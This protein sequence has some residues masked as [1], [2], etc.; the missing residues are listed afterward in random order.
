MKKYLKLALFIA[1]IAA[2]LTVCA[3]AEDGVNEADKT[4]HTYTATASGLTASADYVLLVVK[5]SAVTGTG[6]DAKISGLTADAILYIDQ[7]KSDANGAVS[8]GSPDSTWQPKS[9][10]GGTAFIAGKGLAAPKYLGTLAS[11]GVTVTGDVSY[12]GT[13]TKP[14]LTLSNGSITYTATVGD[15][16][17]GKAAFS[18]VG[19]LDGTYTLKITK[20]GHKTFT[21]TVTIS[22][23]DLDISGKT[24][25]GGDVDGD[26]GITLSDL[27]AILTAYGKSGD[28]ITNKA[29]DIDEDNGITLTDLSVTLTNFG[30]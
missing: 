4:N 11:Y 14:V 3:F 6:S 13:A 2:L 29:L 5:N 1:A 9:F 21:E 22:G 17:S 19:I 27:S 25:Y 12:L 28:G 18:L 23:E 8:F 15:P 24:L 16:V 26:N 20:S 7:Q 30:K 10:A